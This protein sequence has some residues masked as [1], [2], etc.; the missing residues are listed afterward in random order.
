MDRILY[1]AH[2]DADYTKRLNEIATEY[3]AKYTKFVD[4]YSKK[5]GSS[6]FWWATPFAS[7]NI[8]NDETFNNMCYFLLCQ[9]N[10]IGDNKIDHIVLNNK[11]LYDT[12]YK[13]YKQVLKEKKIVLEYCK[14]RKKLFWPILNIYYS[15]KHLV[16]EFYRIK[17]YSSKEQYKTNDYITLIDTPV[18]SSCFQNGEYQDRYF[19]KIQNYTKQS[20]YFL[21]D[22][23][24][25]SSIE[26]KNF[27]QSVDNSK[28]YKFIIKEKFLHLTDYIYLLGYYFYCVILSTKK[29]EYENIDVT[30][31]IKESMLKG[32]YSMPSLKGVVNYRF[33]KRL[34]KTNIKVD[35][36]ISWWEG[37]SSEVMLQKAFRKYYP[38]V[39]SVGYL[40]YPPMEF[41]LS[42]YISNE[43][44]EQNAAP[45][46]MTVPGSLFE[47]QAK[48]FC[49]E[50][51]ILKVPILRNNYSYLVSNDINESQKSILVILSYFEDAAINMLHILNEYMKENKDKFKIYIKNHPVYADKKIDYYIKET[52]FFTPIYVEGDLIKC[53][54]NIDIAYIS[55]ST[56]SLEVLSQGK[57]LINLCPLGELRSTG[58]PEGFSSDGCYFAYGQQEVF[59][60]L[61]ALS[62]ESVGETN[63]GELLEPINE[64]TVNRMWN[65]EME[66]EK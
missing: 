27:V 36:L 61:D 37:R 56:A 58:L 55:Y 42:E 16:K 46:N 6:D 65:N 53:L 21:P 57:N 24:K 38:D 28:E 34:K 50:I 15:I 7:R 29:Y 13:N 17:K 49:K 64:E 3:K 12:L 31:L 54:Q 19:N 11:A 33:I 2:L 43:Q 30:P 10:I 35:N 8:Y 20:I 9:E 51:R 39:N 59:D 32:S 1:L 5:Y 4:K 14:K 44:F 52:L 66:G 63:M 62:K 26:W 22:I 48:Q 45:L 25:N 40:G 60:A 47:E 18:L 23:M 41:G